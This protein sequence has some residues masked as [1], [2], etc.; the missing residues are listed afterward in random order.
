MRALL[1]A[2]I[3]AVFVLP[4][5][6]SNEPSPDVM[7]T[8]YPLEF[9]VSRIAGD[10]LS[11]DSMVPAGVEP[12]EWE[13]TPGDVRRASHSKVFVVLNVEAH[14]SP[15]AWA[16][17]ILLTFDENK[18][19]VIPT[20]TLQDLSLSWIPQEEEEGEHEEEEHQM[21]GPQPDPHVWLDPRRMIAMSMKVEKG[22]S[23][24]D[25]ANKTHYETRGAGLREDLTE[26]DQVYVKRLA[27]CKKND[28]ITSHV[29]F[30]YMA[31][32]YGFIQHGINGLS[33]EVE[34]SPE[35]IRE[36]VDLAR[37][38]N[39]KVVYFESL[40]SANVA[41]VIASEAG[42]KALP[43]NPIEGL[44]QEQ[45]Q[46][47]FADYITLMMDNLDNLVQGLECS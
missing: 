31:E 40:V 3:T 45:E 32:R 26:L 13:P 34:P 6:T 28:I 23:Q 38:L 47:G 8:F 43:L 41:K 14:S 39:V 1:I 46:A 22:L 4:G 27:N 19:L 37:S 44:T 16:E 25:P 11:V 15:D 12:H 24:F 36:L 7:A 42:A 33:P 35:K 30:A 17:E 2:V 29:A 9:L 21:D 5:C 20:T 10:N 18:G